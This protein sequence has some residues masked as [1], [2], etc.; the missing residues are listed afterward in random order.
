[1]MLGGIMMPHDFLPETVQKISMILPASQAMIVFQGLTY[2]LETIMDPF[3]SLAI[4]LVSG[5]I[6]V[7]LAIY[8]FNWDPHNKTS[9]G[10]PIMAAFAF[11]PYAV[12]IFL[13]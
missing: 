2:D 7:G 6:S 9:R 1:M 10:H 12:G 5:V 4:L 8:L 3:V 11:V 13:V